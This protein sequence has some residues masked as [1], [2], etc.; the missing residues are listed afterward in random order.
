MFNCSIDEKLG[1]NAVPEDGAVVPAAP[2]I[3]GLVSFAPNELDAIV[4]PRAPVPPN[5]VAPP[6]FSLSCLFK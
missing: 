2:L 5:E 6:G 4:E 1:L 3:G